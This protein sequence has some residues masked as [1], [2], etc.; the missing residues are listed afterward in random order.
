[1]TEPPSRLL[2]A[3]L[4]K[5][6]VT[7]PWVVGVHS[8]VVGLPAVMEKLEEILNG[9]SCAATTVARMARRESGAK[10]MVAGKA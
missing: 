3:P 2:E 7:G 8:M 4:R 1:M 6:N 9:L 10:C 5:V